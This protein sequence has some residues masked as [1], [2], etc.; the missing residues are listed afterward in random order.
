MLQYLPWHLLIATRLLLDM[1]TASKSRVTAVQV[2]Q[3]IRTVYLEH[4]GAP[5]SV[6][7]GTREHM[8]GE[9]DMRSSMV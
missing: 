7:C 8:L 4:V 5:G 3:Y 9:W 1:V 6:M 2:S